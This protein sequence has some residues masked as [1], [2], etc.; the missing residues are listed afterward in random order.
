[1]KV[2]IIFILV[3]SCLISLTDFVVEIDRDKK[4][5]KKKKRC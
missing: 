2:G 3:Y 4:K 1:M 5:K